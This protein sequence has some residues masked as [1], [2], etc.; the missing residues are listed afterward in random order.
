[1]LGRWTRAAAV[2]AT[3]VVVV[4]GV[5]AG[6]VAA[7]QP[8]CEVR[9]L[10][11]RTTTVGVDALGTALAAAARGARLEVRGV[12]VG[13][14]VISR[15]VTVT[16][17][18]TR[19]VP[20]AAVVGTDAKPT[21]TVARR[22]TA[23]LTRLVLTHDPAA[24]PA[25]SPGLVNHGRTTLY[26]STV[27]GN[28]AASGAGITS[29]GT[30]TLQRSTVSENVA[31]GSGGG[32]LSTGTLVVL[33]STIAGNTGDDGGGIAVSGGRAAFVQATVAANTARWTGGGLLVAAG[34][35]VTASATVLGRNL[36]GAS[37]TDCAG[38]ITSGGWLVVGDA[39]GGWCE[40]TTA[41]GD[42]IDAP[43]GILDVGLESLAWNGGPTRTMLPRADS[44]VVDAV[45]I[46]A[47]ATDGTRLCPGLDQRRVPAPL[48]AACDVGAVER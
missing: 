28:Q 25:A 14:V 23:V 22:T 12:C 6:P 18:A 8:G 15:D 11:A 10:G 40:V 39:D 45:P 7:G 19:A 31:V 29:T 35:P 17:V 27:T 43:V 16:G 42:Q 33:R 32:V 38:P 9:D 41:V 4:A 21:V 3:A 37:G 34:V 44:P 48:G 47:T 13:S 46:G 30:L 20:V 5:S 36:A 1:M 24:D 26:A 2:A